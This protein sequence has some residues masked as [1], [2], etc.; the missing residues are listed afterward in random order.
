MTEAETVGRTLDGAL[1]SDTGEWLSQS[2][3]QRNRC[4]GR[5]L[6]RHGGQE[7]EL[8]GPGERPVGTAAHGAWKEELDPKGLC[9]MFWNL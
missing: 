3:A 2:W 7:P 6:G 8:L 1:T 5:E 4:S 9:S